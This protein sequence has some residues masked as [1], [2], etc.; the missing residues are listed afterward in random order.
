MK[1]KKTLFLVSFLLISILTF[2]QEADTIS[3]QVGKAPLNKGEKQINFGL[4]LNTDGLPVYAQ[5]D[6]AVSRDITVSPMVALTAGNSY[7]FTTIGVHSDYHFNSLLDIPSNWD[8]YAG[9]NLGFRFYMSQ[10]SGT[11]PLHLGLQI[12]G[13]YYWNQRW[14]VNLELGGGAG[15]GSRIGVSRK[16]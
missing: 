16:L 15:F 3:N 10:H 11:S 2:A 4:G 14:G 13:R 1:I 5:L 8:F 6:F 7:S 12:G 9:A